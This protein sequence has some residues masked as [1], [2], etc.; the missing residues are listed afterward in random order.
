MTAGLWL[1]ALVGVVYAA[2]T[3][4]ASSRRSPVYRAA[5]QGDP[6]GAA[7]AV[8]VIAVCWWLLALDDAQR[9]VRRR[10]ARW[11]LH[12]M[13][14]RIQTQSVCTVRPHRSTV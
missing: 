14:R 4:R 10:W 3:H 2:V 1:Y 11:Q 6:A 12:R 7:L 13:L 5:C 9:W 8:L